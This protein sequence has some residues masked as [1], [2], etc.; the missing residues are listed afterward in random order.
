MLAVASGENATNIVSILFANGAKRDCLDESE[1]NLL[2]IAAKYD[3]STILKYLLEN[4]SLSLLDSNVKGD[5][6]LSIARE[7]R[8]QKII[9]ILEAY[10]QRSDPTEK[11]SKDFLEE[12]E[13]EERQ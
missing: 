5:T 12:L 7:K 3:N 4:T 9:E 11:M 6:P 8:N 10:A 1:N 13:K 2:H